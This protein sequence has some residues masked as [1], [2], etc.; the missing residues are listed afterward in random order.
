MTER[1]RQI[2]QWI[3]ENPMISQQE[4]ADKAGIARSSAAVHI[5]NLMKNVYVHSAMGA[6]AKVTISDGRLIIENDGEKE[7][8]REHIFERF[9]Q[10]SQREGSTGLGLALVAAICRSG[11]FPI[12]YYFERGRH[13]FE[14]DFS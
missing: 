12:V 3:Q 1:E 4:L 2:L 11:N 14:I 8:N 5:S 7:L 10:G 13:F 9:Y 6:S